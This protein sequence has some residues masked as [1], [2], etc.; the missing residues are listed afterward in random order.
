[1]VL[2]PA[3][4]LTVV[5]LLIVSGAGYAMSQ[6]GTSSTK[7]WGPQDTHIDHVVILLMENRAFDNYFGTYCPDAGEYCT[8]AV[9][10]EPPGLCVPNVPQDG[11]PN[12]TA[13]VIQEA[14]SEAD[15]L[16]E[17]T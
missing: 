2:G 9:D 10:G 7:S 5:T 4:A 13:S 6:P 16:L 3:F 8:A 1:M 11:E 15:E 14:L 12:L 17:W